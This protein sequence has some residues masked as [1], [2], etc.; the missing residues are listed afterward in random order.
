[1]QTTFQPINIPLLSLVLILVYNDL[2]KISYNAV[3]LQGAGSWY[4]CFYCIVFEQELLL[5]T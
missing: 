5:S 1:M 3:S 4:M 2:R